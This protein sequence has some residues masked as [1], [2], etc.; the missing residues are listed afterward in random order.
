MDDLADTSSPSP[1]TTP[2]SP[3]Y[4]ED[5]PFLAD[6]RV[7]AARMRSHAS[8]AVPQ[9]LPPPPP[10]SAAEVSRTEDERL[11]ALEQ[12]LTPPNAAKL[13]PSGLTADDLENHFCTLY[14]KV[15]ATCI[16]PAFAVVWA[17]NK[18]AFPVAVVAERYL[19]PMLCWCDSWNPEWQMCDFAKAVPTTVSREFSIAMFAVCFVIISGFHLEIDLYIKHFVTKCFAAVRSCCCCLSCV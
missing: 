2:S 1:T 16:S 15:Y 14:R 13:V 17:V 6:A 10:P 11:L 9:L 4:S 19:V 18:L 3:S 8:W 5:T 7:E 12:G